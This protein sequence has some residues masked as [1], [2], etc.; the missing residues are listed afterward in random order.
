MAW[1]QVGYWGDQRLVFQRVLDVSGPVYQA[2]A[3]L[4]GYFLDRGDSAQAESHALEAV[5][6][7]PGEGLGY[8]VLG[9][10]YLARRDYAR[11]EPVLRAAIERSPELAIPWF[12][13]GLALEALGRREDARGAV[14]QALRLQPELAGGRRVLERLR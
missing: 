2:H 12:N 7:A 5:R 9:S 3:A 10:V 6:L 8:A 11:A 13:L 4:S 1:I 14:E